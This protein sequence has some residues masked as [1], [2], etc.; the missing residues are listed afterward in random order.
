M[1]IAFAA[2]A[3]CALTYYVLNLPVKFSILAID[4]CS[5]LLLYNASLILSKPK[6][7]AGSPYLR[8]RWVFKNEGLLI[9]NTVLALLG[10]L[11]ALL[12]VQMG[13]VWFLVGV[14]VLSLSYALPIFTI[15]G[16]KGG[17]RQLPALKLFHIAL[18]WSLST[19][20]LPVLEAWNTGMEINWYQANYLGLT[21]ILFLLICTLPFDIRDMQQDSLYQLKTIPLMIGEHR[22]KI[23]CYGL[24]VLHTLLIALAPYSFPVIGGLLVTNVL[25]GLTMWLLLFRH[26]KHYHYVYLLDFALIVQFVL[27]FVS[28]CFFR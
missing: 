5:T 15:G 21:K 24:L 22:A 7:P 1:L 10:L 13:T 2:V 9:V 12:H 25:I 16:T 3:Q 19:V 23:V 18:I 27:V 28:I 26:I 8:T 4:G 11:Y 17:L 6:N 14:A 20:G